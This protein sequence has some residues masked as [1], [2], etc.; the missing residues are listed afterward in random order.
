MVPQV[1][2]TIF[3]RQGLSFAWSL[4]MRLG[5]LASVLQGYLSPQYWDYTQEPKNKQTKKLGFNISLGDQTQGLLQ[6]CY[7][8]K[9]LPIPAFQ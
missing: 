1:M 3:L 5:W 9:A 7:W 6:A 8:L 4:P 2:S